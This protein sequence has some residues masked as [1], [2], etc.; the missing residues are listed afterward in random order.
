MCC[1]PAHLSAYLRTL[2]APTQCAPCFT[3]PGWFSYN[4]DEKTGT[5]TVIVGPR[6]APWVNVSLAA[7]SNYP[8]SFDACEM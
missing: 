6:A 1:M 2:N 4:K 3:S 8:G 7:P 5:T